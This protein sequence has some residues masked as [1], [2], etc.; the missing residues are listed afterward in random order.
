MG[1]EEVLALLL[2][3]ERTVR[4]SLSVLLCGVLQLYVELSR[5]DTAAYTP[6]LKDACSSTCTVPK[7]CKGMKIMR[8]SASCREEDMSNAAGTLPTLL[9]GEVKREVKRATSCSAISDEGPACKE[10]LLHTG[11]KEKRH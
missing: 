2:G 5:L 8:K 6:A 3:H 10:F 1:N 4:G 7:S 9:R 11:V